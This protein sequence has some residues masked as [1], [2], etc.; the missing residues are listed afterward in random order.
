M[1]DSLDSGSSVHCGRA[2]SSPASPTK[3]NKTSIWVSCFLYASQ[4]ELER[5]NATRTSV[6]VAGLTATNIY[7]CPI[8]AK[9]QTSP[10]LPTKRKAGRKLFYLLFSLVFRT[11]SVVSQLLV[12][13]WLNTR[14]VFLTSERQ[15]LH[16]N[17]NENGNEIIQRTLRWC[18]HGRTHPSW[19]CACRSFAWF[20]CQP[21]R[22][23]P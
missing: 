17:G 14:F 10:A 18:L 11:I 7:F 15:F 19:K 13:K 8:W 3:N 21:N 2:G 12:L 23:F 20:G 4:A 9:M 6:A 16:K 5:L 22:R 1:V